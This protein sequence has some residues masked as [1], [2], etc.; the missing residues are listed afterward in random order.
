MHCNRLAAVRQQRKPWDCASFKHDHQVVGPRNAMEWAV[1]HSCGV[2]PRGRHRLSFML[3]AAAFHSLAGMQG[4][5]TTCRV[6]A[7]RRRKH[8]LMI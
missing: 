1:Q 7:K 4:N 6:V 3:T 8:H 2:S 5:D